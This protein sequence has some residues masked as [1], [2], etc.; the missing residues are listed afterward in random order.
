[1]KENVYKELKTLENM[2]INWT[3]DYVKHIDPYGGNDYLIKDFNEEI[4]HHLIPYLRRLHQCDYLTLQ[5]MH[6][7]SG[8]ISVHIFNFLDYMKE[9]DEVA[10]AEKVKNE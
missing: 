1:M 9:I 10:E 4:E 6:E 3:R 5:E 8:V 7:F 2:L